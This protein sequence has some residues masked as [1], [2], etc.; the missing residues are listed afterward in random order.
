MAAMPRNPNDLATGTPMRN[1]ILAL[2]A[3]TALAASATSAQ[4]QRYRWL[5]QGQCSSMGGRWQPAAIARPDSN[6]LQPCDLGSN[7]S[8]SRDP[9]PSPRHNG[10]VSAPRGPTSDISG[11]GN[12][13]AAAATLAVA[14]VQILGALVQSLEPPPRNVLAERLEAERLDRERRD[15]SD[16]KAKAASASAL[17]EEARRLA[18]SGRDDEA[19][20]SMFRRAWTTAN[21][22]GAHNEGLVYYRNM[23][24]M[25]AKKRYAIA[26]AAAKAGDL[27]KAS[28]NL[29]A[30]ATFATTAENRDLANRI[31]AQRQEIDRSAAALPAPQR[32]GVMDSTRHCTQINGEMLCN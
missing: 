32:A 20:L 12:R 29:A 8:T 11:L 6:S 24:T 7:Y 19:A 21:G 15:E 3:L 4:A 18:A 26:L 27:R 9:G 30:A 5:T 10:R 14:G 22:A 16:R 25:L 13:A 1:A 2:A 23:N 17:N 28:R 31:L